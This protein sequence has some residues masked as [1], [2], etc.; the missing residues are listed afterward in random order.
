MLGAR[1]LIF[2]L[3]VQCPKTVKHLR[4]DEDVTLHHQLNSIFPNLN[5]YFLGVSVFFP[6]EFYFSEETKAPILDYVCARLT[7]ALSYDL[8]VFVCVA[9][10]KFSATN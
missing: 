7:P 6:R 1:T 2:W 3:R 9:R 10:Y 4:S 5:V 8:N